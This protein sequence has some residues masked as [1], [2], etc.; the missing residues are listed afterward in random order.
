MTTSRAWKSAPGPVGSPWLFFLPNRLRVVLSQ[1]RAFVRNPLD[2]LLQSARQHGD[3]A[4]LDPGRVYLINR[5][6]F[7]QYVLQDNHA[8]YCKGSSYQFYNVFGI[9][10]LV[11]D[12]EVWRRQRRLVQPAFGRKHDEA[13]V[14]IM[15]EA[16]NA[17]MTRWAAIV[18]RGVAVDIRQEMSRLTLS[19]FL[20]AMFSAEAGEELD[21]VARAFLI[22]E[23]SLN[24]SAT[25]LP[26][27][28]P[29]NL[30]TP[31]QRRV[32][33]AIA[34]LDSFVY[35]LIDERRRSGE[36]TGDL[37]SRLLDARDEETGEGLSRQQVRDQTL[38]L[39][40][41]GHELTTDAMTWTWYLLSKH[42]TVARRLHDEID[43][44]LAS[45]AP[46]LPDVSKLTYT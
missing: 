29:K 18:D 42:S 8:N 12:G 45:R 37:L 38:T 3:I 19:V 10:L 16:T 2:H 5:P 34:A 15:I 26:I 13:F 17:M 46:A 23:R 22:V 40:N 25:F 32:R 33:Q 21:D 39:M 41:A 1:T 14:T 4:C 27:Q 11:S 31:G 7:I 6:E 36:R 28:W 43:E 9:G 24:P 30:P 35:R 44:L 20:K